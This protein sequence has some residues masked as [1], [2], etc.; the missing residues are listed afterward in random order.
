MKKMLFA[1]LLILCGF[2]FMITCYILSVLNPWNYNGYDGFFTFLMGTKSI[3]MFF[4]SSV[5]VACGFTIAYNEA[6][7]KDKE[8]KSK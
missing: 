6:F 8:N 1:T 3:L 4:L 5:L 2:T 7:G